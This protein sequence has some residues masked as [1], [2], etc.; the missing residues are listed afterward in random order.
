MITLHPLSTT[1]NFTIESM[2]LTNDTNIFIRTE[3]ADCLEKR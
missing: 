2:L 1:R 3:A